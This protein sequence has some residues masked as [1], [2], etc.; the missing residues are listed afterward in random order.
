MGTVLVKHGDGSRVSSRFFM[1]HEKN[2][3]A[4]HGSLKAQKSKT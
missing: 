1:K 2:E 3:I 4:P